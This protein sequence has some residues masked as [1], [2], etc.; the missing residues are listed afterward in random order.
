MTVNPGFGGQKFMREC[1]SKVSAGADR[2]RHEGY[3]FHLEVD[4]GI[5]VETA[6]EARQAGANVFVA[7]TS[8]FGKADY[9]AAVRALRGD[10][11]G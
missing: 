10:S 4:G 6:A 1:L 3:S 2:R 7:G 8:F 5:N 11:I 9:A